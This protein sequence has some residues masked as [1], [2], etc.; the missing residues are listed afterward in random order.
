MTNFE[1]L[2]SI[3]SDVHKDAYGFR[4]RDWAT[5]RSK[6][7]AQLQAEIDEMCK[8]ADAEIAREQEAE[9]ACADELNAYL[10]KL[11][12]DHAISMGTAIRWDMEAYGCEN[13]LEHYLWSRGVG[14]G[15]LAYETKAKFASLLS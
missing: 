7:E 14:C 11:V 15:R 3:Y 12:A 9:K 2:L 6:T 13:D 4:P 5:I 10:A 1:S 8:D